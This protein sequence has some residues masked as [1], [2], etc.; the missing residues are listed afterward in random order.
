MKLIVSP[1]I[2]SVPSLAEQVHTASTLLEESIGQAAERATAEWAPSR[3]DRGRPR[4]ELR[5][6]DWAGEASAL[7][8]P[9]ELTP[10]ARLR[11]RF[12]DVWGDVLQ[13]GSHRLIQRIKES[14]AT[15]S[16]G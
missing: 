14:S 7:F 13:V 6:S 10:D 4:L 12:R 5:L 15:A 11:Q 1:E 16:G 9:E 2:E 3:D 8:A